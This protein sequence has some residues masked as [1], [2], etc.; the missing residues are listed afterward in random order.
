MAG[1]WIDDR[2]WAVEGAEFNPDGAIYKLWRKL[3]SEGTYLGI[4]LTP[5]IE[6][7]VGVQQGFSSGM[8]LGWS[9]EQGAYVASDQ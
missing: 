9:T 8:V 6:T 4:P 3:R 1:S 7:P 2:L 5:E